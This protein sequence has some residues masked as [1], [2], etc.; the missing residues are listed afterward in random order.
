MKLLS[1]CCGNFSTN[2]SQPA[3]HVLV[4]HILVAASALRKNYFYMACHAAPCR[5]KASAPAKSANLSAKAASR[6]ALLSPP[7]QHRFLMT[8]DR[9]G[10]GM[11]WLPSTQRRRPMNEVEGNVAGLAI[12]W[13][14]NRR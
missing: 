9:R 2:F 1:T 5:G 3:A 8:P 6:E 12:S 4:I 7:K 14:C 13:Q 10:I 11:V